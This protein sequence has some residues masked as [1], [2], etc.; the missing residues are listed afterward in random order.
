M[1]YFI[2]FLFSAVFAALTGGA[3]TYAAEFE[4]LDRFSVDGYSVLKGSADIPGGSFTVGGSTLVVKGGNVGIG[5]AAPAGKLHLYVQEDT[6]SPVL[7]IKRGNNSGG[8]LG[9]PEIGIDVS[10]PN[11]YNSAGT[12]YGVRSVVNHNLGGPHY[13]GYFET[14]GNAYGNGIG[15]YAK[16]THTDTNGP[17]FQP[18]ILA[19]A[20]SNIGVSNAGYAVAVQANTND[21]VNNVNLLLKSDYTGAANQN[22]VIINRNGSDLGYV[23]TNATSISFLTSSASGLI[24]IDANTL[25]INTSS[26]ERMRITS[27]GNVGIGTTNPAKL[28]QVSGTG[29]YSSA[30]EQVRITDTAGGA[31]VS[32][33][34]D[35]VKGIGAIYAGIPGT[36]YIPLYIGLGSTN[37][38]VNANGGNVGIGTTS[39]AAALDVGGTGAIKVPV[40]T[41][42]ERPASPV[43]GMIRFNSTTGRME[44]Y[45]NGGWNSFVGAVTATG[46]NTVNDIGGYRIHT[47]TSGGAFVV[48]GGGNVEVLVV[49]G[50]GSGGAGN[51]SAG[52]GAGGLLYSSALPVSAQTYTVTVGGGG[53]NGNGQNSAFGTLLTAIGGGKGGQSAATGSV[54]GSGGGGGYSAPSGYYG[55]AGTA[56]QGNAGGRGDSTA[57]FGWGGGGGGAGGV[58]ADAVHYSNPGNGGIGLAY[59][60]SGTSTYYA[61]GGGGGIDS[62]G[63]RSYGGNG[64]GGWGDSTSTANNP[65]T[66]GTANTGGGGGGIGGSGGSGVVIIRY[67]I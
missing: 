17:G 1:C 60:I 40:G 37:T 65:G 48:T 57:G 44:Y 59:S 33:L 39:P 54:G 13:A 42:T 3:L 5:T 10:I 63:Y 30:A 14:A 47:F 28:L 43:I 46:G 34:A 7:Y 61:G 62:S 2:K 4:V 53:V 8:G 29:T 36:G 67:P 55:G 58:G 27:A 51:Y 12:V 50:G 66:A 45:N 49:A 16:T 23:R 19:D 9:N 35:G 56:G 26:N 52:G 11:T 6:A 21:Y 18:A 41:T 64:G 15:V 32:L 31:T 22:A 24:G 38:I 25:A 20:Y